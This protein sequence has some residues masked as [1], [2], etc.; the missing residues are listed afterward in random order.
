MNRKFTALAAAST[1]GL[2]LALSFANG[3]AAQSQSPMVPELEWNTPLKHFQM[4]SDKFVGQRFTAKCPPRSL[5]DEDE[6]IQGTDAY[7]STNPICVAALHAGEIT[8]DGGLITL[9]LNP[10]LESYQGSERNG[11]AS[12]DLPG[13]KRS[14]VF[15]NAKTAAAAD[16]AQ[17]PYIQ[18]IDWNTKFTSTGLANKDLVGQQFTFNCA[19]APAGKKL[20]RISGTDSYAFASFVCVAALHAGKITT[21]GGLVT[22]QM[23]PGKDKLV[24]SI[25]NGVESKDGPGGH[26]TIS[27]VD[28]PVAQ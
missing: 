20:R 19:S 3:A 18:R 28:A 11:I 17:Q 8:T 25:R 12:A 9:Q 15:V 7:P 5:R 22:V 2:T 10:G 23:D 4:D 6:A 21:D 1:V 27:F 16:A 14:I 26:T 13:T 24:G